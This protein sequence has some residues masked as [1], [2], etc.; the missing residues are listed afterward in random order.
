MY[1]ANGYL[2]ACEEVVV[3]ER[4]KHDPLSSPCWLVNRSVYERKTQTEKR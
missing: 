1:V 3:V 4:S 2:N